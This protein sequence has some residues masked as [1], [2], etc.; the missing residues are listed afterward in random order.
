[1][2]YLRIGWIVL[3]IMLLLGLQSPAYGQEGPN[4]LRNG[5]FEEG[6]PGQAWPFQDGIPE[7]QVAP[8]WRAFFLD[9]PPPYAVAPDY[10][11]GDV[12]CA[13]GRPEF[14]GVASYEFSYRVRSGQLAQKYFSWNR[15]HEAGLY[16]QVSGIRPGTRLRF[17]VWVHTWSCMPA[18]GTWNECR[19]TPFS[20][21]PAPMHVW[22]G[23]DPTGGTDW[24]APTVVR[25]PE[26]NAWDQWTLFQVEAVAQSDKV[27]VFIH[28]RADWQ[29]R[30]PRINNDV[31]IDD[32]SLVALGQATPTPLPPPPTAAATPASPQQPTRA[33]APSPTSRPD[34]CRV[35]IVQSGDT[36][37]GIALQYGIPLEELQRLNAGSLGPNNMIWVGQEIILSCPTPTPTPAATPTPEPTPTPQSG[38]VCVLAFHD[39]NGDGT[40]QPE[41]EELLPNAVLILSN[42]TGLVGQYTTD[43]ISEPYCFPGLPPGAYEVAVQP[44]AGYGV[45]GPAQVALALTPGGSL[46]AAIPLQRGA[47]TGATPVAVLPT[48]ESEETPTARPSIWP[49]VLRWGARIGGLL[50]LGL[51]ILIPVRWLLSR[52]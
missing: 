46:E 52:R 43:G 37:F 49:Q 9:Y 44:P 34:G 8:G 19:T 13:W 30:I 22:V 5:D 28:T 38:Q 51:V 17:S 3:S 41:T 7:V 4:L 18:P 35:H 33:P 21:S 16:Q 36:L 29:D 20:D 47:S 11:G 32:A 27:T 48:P 1:M 25:S 14:R 6:G 10:C 12:R 45:N 50:L 23:I 2:K 39:R 24:A 15:Q 42:P 40:R 31:Y 26:G